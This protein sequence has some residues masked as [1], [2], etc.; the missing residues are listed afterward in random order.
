MARERSNNAQPDA[1]ISIIGPGMTIVGDIISDGTV[2][3]EG[4]VEGSITAG[5]AIV[6][7]RGG[8]VRGDVRTQDAVIAGTLD[9]TL[10]AESRL[11][12]QASAVLNCTVRA[13]LVQLEEGAVL[14]GSVEMGES[15]VRSGDSSDAAEKA[16]DV[17]AETTVEV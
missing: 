7:G 17:L 6:I 12:V 2:R 8:S 13:R 15:V 11:E 1:A 3:V 5:K 9:G 4:V 16:P 14:N 10:M